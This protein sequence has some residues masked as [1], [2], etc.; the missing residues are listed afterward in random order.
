M[1]LP[2]NYRLLLC[3]AFLAG[4]TALAA[5]SH[6]AGNEQTLSVRIDLITGTSV[7]VAV[8]GQAPDGSV[9]VA[10]S[11]SQFQKADSLTMAAD[12]QNLPDDLIVLLSY[13][14]NLVG[15]EPVLQAGAAPAGDFQAI[16][17]KGILYSP[18]NRGTQFTAPSGCNSRIREW[19][20]RRE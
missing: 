20:M 6:K 10:Y 16:V 19:G 14:E 4:A 1:K 2:L 17:P 9:S 5:C 18:L 3:S 12:V 11:S 15:Q 8:I 7:L 13:D